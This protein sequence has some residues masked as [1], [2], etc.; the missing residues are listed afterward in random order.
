MLSSNS[1]PRHLLHR[2]LRDIPQSN[3]THRLPNPQSN[4]RR[5]TPV[6]SFDT[7]L[8]V[9]VRE[10]VADG[11]LRRTVR[12]DG[13][14]LHFHAHDF[15]GLV[16]GR[17]TSSESGGEDSFWGGEFLSFGFTV[18][19]ADAV[20]T[21]RQS[22][23]SRE[24]SS[25][26]PKRKRM[27]YSRNTTQ[28]K[29]R[30]PISNLPHSNRINSLINPSNSLGAIDPHERRKRARRFDSRFH[31]LVLRDL[32]RLHARAESHGRVGL[33]ETA[34]HATADARD[35]V[36]GAEGFG[37]EFSFRGDEEEDGAF[38]RGFDPG[39]G[40]E[41]LVD[42]SHITISVSFAPPITRL[43]ANTRRRRR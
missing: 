6:Q 2:L 14:G 30:P 19:G 27:L 34:R 8:L 5:N 38:G 16:P 35:K 17:E 31:S 15:D 13:F 12:V 26:V 20:F 37:V 29:P 42:Y 24:L 11:H 4:P 43:A 9:N 25:G 32:H 21:R 7:I 22:D 1:L 18:E 33:C 23:V 28:P 41:S 40:D 39:P 36:A 10:S 3:H